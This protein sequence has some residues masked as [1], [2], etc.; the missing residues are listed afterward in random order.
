MTLSA[1]L[2]LAFLNPILFFM[3]SAGETAAQPYAAESKT[4]PTSQEIKNTLPDMGILPV[5]EQSFIAIGTRN[6]FYPIRNWNFQLPELSAKSALVAD[7][8]QATILFEKDAGTQYPIASLTKIMTALIALELYNPDDFIALSKEA[9]AIEGNRVGLKIGEEL[10]V[11]D[12][13]TAM[14]VSSSNEAAAALAEKAGTGYF[15]EKMN[16]KARNLG[17]LQT[18]YSNPVGLDDVNHFSTAYDLLT[19]ARAV[20]TNGEWWNISKLPTA[21]ITGKGGT[22]EHTLVNTNR[23][24]DTR[25]DILA[26]KTG[27]TDQARGALILVVL[28][29]YLIS[30]ESDPEALVLIL[31]GSEDRFSDAHTLLTWIE[32]AYIWR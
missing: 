25:H 24:L 23:M 32:K 30:S 28:K 1:A 29:P 10:T 11:R 4:L 6:A 22:Q 17:L 20:K 18:H 16:E 7:L 15:V 12:L 5:T 27:F 2:L 9:A 21:V 31:L 19:L 8:G 3:S 13:V 26:G 14:L